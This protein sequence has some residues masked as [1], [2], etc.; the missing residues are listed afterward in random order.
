MNLG[1]YNH[2]IK[3]YLTHPLYD[4]TY[5]E[6]RH[7]IPPG[8]SYNHNAC[9][10]LGPGGIKIR[11][12]G[13]RYYTLIEVGVDSNDDYRMTFFD[14]TTQTGV[15]EILPTWQECGGIAVDTVQVPAGAVEKGYD[16]ILIVPV[17]GDDAYSF[18]HLRY[19][20]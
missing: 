4:L 7:P 3:A 9:R 5:D 1:F 18:G 20:R 11:F 19:L 8:T 15:V 14:G 16:N 17:K 10:L 13:R 6:V 12:D 2:Y